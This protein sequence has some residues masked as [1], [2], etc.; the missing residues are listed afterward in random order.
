LGPRVDLTRSPRARAPTKE[1]RRAFSARSSVALRVERW[2][3]GN[4][5]EWES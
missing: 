4:G 2:I 3:R 5:C 1:E